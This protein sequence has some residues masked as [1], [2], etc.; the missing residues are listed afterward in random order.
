MK[1]AKGHGSNPRGSHASGVD[2]VGRAPKVNDAAMNIIRGTKPGEGFSVTPGGKTPTTG[3]M[4]AL[5]S[6][7]TSVNPAD[8]HGGRAQDI[9]N[10]HMQANAD[11]YSN[12]PNMHIGGWH[13]PDSKM[14]SID[15]AENIKDR[16]TAIRLGVER[17]QKAIYDLKNKRDIETGGTGT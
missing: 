15:P 12:N 11:V 1:D 8:L 4:V 10:G 17:N 14:M 9:I 13:D 3:Y 6:R 5:P 2:Q 16:S 7:T